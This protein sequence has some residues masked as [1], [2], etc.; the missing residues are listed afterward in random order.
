M[1]TRFIKSR[2]DLILTSAF[3]LNCAMQLVSIFINRLLGLPPEEYPYSGALIALPILH[4]TSLLVLYAMIFTQRLRDEYV[5]KLWQ[6]AARGFAMVILLL[7]WLWLLTWAF[8]GLVMPEA[9]WLPTD[10]KQPLLPMT[11]DDPASISH[12]QMD[13]VSY[14]LGKL[15][16]YCPLVFVAL[17]KWHA[18]RDKA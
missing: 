12:H 7:P 3:L 9:Y 16:T 1:I 15:W 5:E 11:G 17:F 2:Y 13:G 8:K 4:L 18:W 6:R 14:V 10:P